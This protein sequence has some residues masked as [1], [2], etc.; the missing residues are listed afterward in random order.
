MKKKINKKQKRKKKLIKFF[1]YK[2]MKILSQFYQIMKNNK[3]LL[4]NK[5]KVT[6]AQKKVK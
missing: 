3:Q 5:M 2:R 1:K 4:T 6:K